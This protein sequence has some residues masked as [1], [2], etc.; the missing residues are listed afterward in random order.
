MMFP[1]TPA[2]RVI[3]FALPTTVFST[4]TLSFVPGLTRPMPK[5]FPWAAY[6]FPL[7]RFARSRLRLAPPASHIPPQGEVLLPLLTPVFAT[8]SLSVEAPVTKIP[9]RQLVA[10]VTWVTST[11]ELAPVITIP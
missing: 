8:R 2:T 10:T 4:I 9:D 3:P 1:S 7:N 6:P 11:R 5:L